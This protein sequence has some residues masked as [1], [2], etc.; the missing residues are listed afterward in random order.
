MDKKL[1]FD[2]ETGPTWPHEAELDV[3]ENVMREKILT[4]VW[5]SFVKDEF[6]L[7]NLIKTMAEISYAIAVMDRYAT[8]SMK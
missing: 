8:G 5:T 7:T 1:F 3:E 2:E 6:G 4:R